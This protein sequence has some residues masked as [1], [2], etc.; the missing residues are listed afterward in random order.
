MKIRNLFYCAVA[1]TFLFTSC[2]PEEPETPEV[3]EVTTSIY[4]VDFEDV[5]LGEQGYVNGSDGSGKFVSGN[6]E[7]LNTYTVSEWG[8]FWDGFACSN[9]TDVETTGFMN[10][11]SAIP[12]KGAANTERYAVGYMPFTSDLTFNCPKNEQGYF[13][14]N[15]MMVTN[16]TYAYLAMKD[17]DEY[18]KKFSTGDW[19][20][21][22]IKGYKGK[23]ET[24]SVDYY[25]ADF[26]DGKTFISN[27]WEKLDV[28]TLGEVDKVIFLFDSTDKSTFGINNPTYICVDNIEF[29][30][31]V[32]EVK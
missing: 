28:S 9:H 4:F 26:R 15:S 8:A 2:T 25:L 11:F 16:S 3:P 1:L 27:K 10:E 7:F 19:Y 6:C 24:G 13:R 30:Q 21:I 31:E 14:I 5:E 17:G 12:G 23:T 22:T 20:K 32:V 18:A 29:T